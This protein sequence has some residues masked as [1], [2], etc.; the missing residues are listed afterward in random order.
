MAKTVFMTSLAEENFE[1]VV[2]YLLANWSEKTAKN[3]VV[4]FERIYQFISDTPALYPFINKEKRVQKCVLTK[5]N[6]LYFREDENAIIIL[7]VFDTRQSPEK[8]KI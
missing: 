8:L 5:H 7:D 1:T 2:K 6:V 3:F 4:K